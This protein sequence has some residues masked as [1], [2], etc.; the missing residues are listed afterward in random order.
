MVLNE[1]LTS[2]GH[3]IVSFKSQQEA[4]AFVASANEFHL[5]LLD[6]S[7]PDGPGSEIAEEILR[8]K[9]GI[10]V[11]MMTGFVSEML[12]LPYGLR[13]RVTV[14][15]KPFPLTKVRELIGLFFPPSAV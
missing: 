5:A 6:Y 12:P 11:I 10:P 2:L 7:L 1:V 13:D 8:R 15:E 3:R 4:L 14:L 9:P